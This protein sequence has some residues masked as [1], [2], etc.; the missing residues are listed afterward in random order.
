MKRKGETALIRQIALR[1]GAELTL[2][3][4]L[5]LWE[6]GN[7]RP[8]SAFERLMLEYVESRCGSPRAARHLLL[9]L[10]GRMHTTMHLLLEWEQ[11]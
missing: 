1:Y 2:G 5:E 4:L 3:T 11:A 9:E 8:A 6:V 7:S 10:T